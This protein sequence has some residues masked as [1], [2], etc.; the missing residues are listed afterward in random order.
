MKKRINKKIDKKEILENKIHKI[1]FVLAVVIGIILSVG[2]PLFSEPDGQWHYS[3]STNMVHL[4][5][6]LSAYG[7]PVGTGLNVQKSAYQRGNH[8]E[9]YFE[10]KIVKMPIQNIPRT[11]SIPPVLSSNFLGHLIPAI[12]V[13]IGYHI[14]PSAGVMIVVGRLFSSIISSFI[15]CLIIK[16]IQKGKLVVFAL[17]LTPV[18]AGTL[19]SLTYD[20]FSYLLALLVFLITT[21]LLVTKQITWKRIASIGIVSVLI[22]LGAKTNVKLLLL[23][24]PL[25]LFIL[26]FEKFKDKRKIHF[27]FRGRKLW[28]FSMV[29]LGFIVIA[30]GIIFTIK[31]SLIFSIYR[32]IINFSVN[33]SPSLSMNNIFLGLLASPYPSYNYMPYWVAGAWYVIILLSMLVDK[34][35]ISKWVGL[36]AIA[37]FFINFLGVYHGFLTFQ[38]GGYA[39]APRSVI[40]GSIYGQQGRYFTPFLLVL[41]LALASSKI[42]LQVVSGQAVLWLSAMLAIVSNIILLFATLFGIYYL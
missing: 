23:L 6:D 7:E 12:G 25:V 27:E 38:G 22:V 14:Y 41:A 34:Y 4:S 11:N 3:V 15:I 21:N 2:M 9:Q 33:L 30:M 39:P 32:I 16:K 42:R 24:F 20:T 13:W 31:P 5:N 29:I 35:P 18:I 37:I 28:I 10:N 8:F 17:S 19:A 26:V 1:Y 40:M 36:G